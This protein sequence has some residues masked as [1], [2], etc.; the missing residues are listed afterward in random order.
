MI[1]HS[2]LPPPLSHDVPMALLGTKV[3]V[4]SARK[5]CLLLTSVQLAPSPQVLAPFAP[6]L[7]VPALASLEPI[8]STHPVVCGLKVLLLI[9]SSW[10]NPCFLSM[11][12]TLGSINPLAWHLLVPFA[13]LNHHCVKPLR[14]STVDGGLMSAC[15]LQYHHAQYVP[16]SPPECPPS[17]NNSRANG[18]SG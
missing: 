6:A 11:M 4:C 13:S 12:H 2:R 14:Q 9:N 1:S 5:P 8:G 16:P 17:K 7:T 15:E 18:H 3:C 10:T